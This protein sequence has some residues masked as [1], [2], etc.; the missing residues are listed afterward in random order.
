MGAEFKQ[1]QPTLIGA[2]WDRENEYTSPDGNWTPYFKGPLAVIGEDNILTRTTAKELIVEDGKVTGVKAVMFDGTEVTAHASKGVILATGGYAANIDLVLKDNQYWDSAYLTKSTKTTNRSSQVGDGIVM[3]QAVGA[4]TTGMNFTQLMPISWVDNGNLAFGSGTYACWVSPSTGKRFVDEGS[5][6]DVLSLAEFRNGMELNGTP[7]VFIEFFNADQYI[8]GPPTAQ[9]P[10]DEFPGRYYKIKC[11]EEELAKVLAKPEFA[12]VTADAATMLATVKAYDQA[13][14]EKANTGSADFGEIGK[15]VFSRTIGNV[16]KGE[17]G[18]YKTETYDLD[19]T[20]VFVRLMAPSTHHTMGG[21]VVDTKRHVLNENGE[22]IP[23]LFAAGEVT[24]GIHGGNRL[25]G[26][27]IVEI[28][29]S[30]RTAA[31]AVAADNP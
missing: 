8:P 3:A 7:G 1:T 30:G 11:N 2:L 5:E 10:L 19:N 9:L 24:G 6:R 14:M 16:E 12:N 23:G 20:V 4:A 31:K 27:A 21:L 25:G 17:D 29:V 13:V 26:N 15:K 18:K 28:F 22:I